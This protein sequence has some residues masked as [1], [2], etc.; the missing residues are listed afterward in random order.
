MTSQQTTGRKRRCGW[1]DLVVLQYSHMINHYSFINLT[2]LD[3]LDQLDE[4]QV[5][6]RYL[7][8]DVIDLAWD[9]TT[10]RYMVNGQP[11]ESFPADL[12]VLEKVVVEYVTLPGW[13]TDISKCRRYGELPEN[14]KKYVEYI[15]TF[16]GVKGRF[17]V[18][19]EG[20]AFL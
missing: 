15:E 10:K 4:I 13:K 20:L 8:K 16:L 3:V 11:L 9:L 12:S 18:F 1:L 17:F 14:A 2:K 7:L 5:G 19:L 6:V